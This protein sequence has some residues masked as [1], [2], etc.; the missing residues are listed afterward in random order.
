[1]ALSEKYQEKVAFVVIDVEKQDDPSVETLAKDFNVQYIPTI[2]FIDSRGQIVKQHVG[3][4][5]EEELTK[6]IDQ[7]IE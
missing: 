3:A 4:V 1:M 6:E 5:S 2:I 7:L